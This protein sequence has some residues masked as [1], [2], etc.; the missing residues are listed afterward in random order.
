MHVCVGAQGSWVSVLLSWQAG[1]ACL[2]TTAPMLFA[3]RKLGFVL[4][5]TKSSLTA[6]HCTQPHPQV[7]FV[8]PVRICGLVSKRVG[9]LCFCR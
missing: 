6:V 8:P 5:W 2:E 1:A 7:R 3:S 9:Y 4:S